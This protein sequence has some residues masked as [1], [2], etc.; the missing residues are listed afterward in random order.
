MEISTEQEHVSADPT[1]ESTESL[2]DW[3]NPPTVGNFKQDFTDAQSDQTDHISK[4][5]A[6][7][8]NLNITNAAKLPDKKGFSRVQP[9]LIRKQ[10]EWRYAS[11]SE[12]FLSTDDIF[13]ADPVTF[14]DKKAA[15]QNGL[16]LNNQFNTVID[17][18]AF[19]DEYVRAAVDEGTT[20]VRVGWAYEDIKHLVDVPKYKYV[21]STAPEVVQ[22]NQQLHELM[23][24]DPGQYQE[25]V[26]EHLKIAHTLAMESG[27]PVEAIQIGTETEEKITVLRNEPTVDPVN[28]KNISIDPSCGGV[29]SKAEFVIYSYETSLAELKKSDKYQN[30]DQ[31]NV[32]TQSALADPD[33]DSD[34]NSSFA[35]SD[36]PRKKIIAR[37]YWGN[38]D[39][40][41]DGT[42][43]PIVG[44][45]VGDVMIHLGE[46]PFPDKKHPFVLAQYLPVRK[47]LYGE[48]DGE[49]LI[50]NQKIVGA[51]T[52]GMID[53]MGRS[54]NGQQGTKKGTL[55]VTNKR[56]YDKGEDY[57]FNA[58]D[59]P[60]AAFH[61]HTYPEIPQSAPYMLAAQNADA[62]SLTGVK[63][64]SGPQG[65]TGSALGENV[66][67]IKT[68]LDA[69]AKRELGI[70]RRLANGM[71]EIGRKIISMNAEFLEEEEV[72]RITNE[73]FVT[74]RRD[75][76]AGNFDLKLTIST[77]EADEA[78]AAELS[79]M[80]QTTAQHMG[81]A[82]TQI[83][84]ADIAKLRKM[85]DLAKR[86]EDFEPTP[87]PVAQEKAALE[88][89]LLKAQIRETNSKTVENMAEAELDRAKATTEGSKAGNLNSDT[90]LKNLDFVE[91]ETGTKQ[92]RALEQQ[93]ESAKANAEGKTIEHALKQNEIPSESSVGDVTTTNG[94]QPV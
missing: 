27:D 51:V 82:F 87:D 49:L 25:T 18:V 57:E 5:D 70:L 79:F 20:I 94:L 81:P 34:K 58:G 77:P 73:E 83:I 80:L 47:S 12:P 46:N 54:A 76:L 89:E 42:V 2:T 44:T 1:K 93:N 39:I 15:L 41:G 91:Q 59:D 53:T 7:L 85:P 50:D 67:G 55:D 3:K 9:K 88:I 29:L 31:I 6:W 64:F 92:E 60:R 56:K 62:E 4:V 37:E 86:I 74:V 65:I 43:K 30:L 69:T 17:K 38:W 63:A 28:Y 84:M 72:V 68:A 23:Q 11:L 48:P 22:L 75:D 10:A 32:E 90:D 19:I 33:H 71:K 61:M 24:R 78:K 66:G 52:R 45:Y 40:D 35:F 26:P 36:K 13:N 16:V 21:P 14:E 8:D